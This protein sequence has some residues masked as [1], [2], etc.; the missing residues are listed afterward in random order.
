MDSDDLL[1]EED[2]VKPDPATLRSESIIAPRVDSRGRYIQ[3]IDST[4][5]YL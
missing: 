5:I 3:Y 1:A 2:L 4:N